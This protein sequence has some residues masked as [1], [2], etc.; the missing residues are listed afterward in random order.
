LY[1]IRD[2]IETETFVTFRITETDEKFLHEVFSDSN[3][4]PGSLTVSAEVFKLDGQVLM[5]VNIGGSSSVIW[6]LDGNDAV[7]DVTS[8]N[9]GNVFTALA[10]GSFSL[11]TSLSG[12]IQSEGKWSAAG[13]GVIN[14]ELILDGYEAL[15]FW[16][17]ISTV[18]TIAGSAHPDVA[19]SLEAQVTNMLTS[20]E[21]YFDFPSDAG[22]FAG[23]INGILAVG[24][25]YMVGPDEISYLYAT[26]ESTRY[27]QIWVGE[28]L[29]FDA[30][31]NS[32]GTNSELY[33]YSQPSGDS[34]NDHY[35][36]YRR[37]VTGDDIR[38]IISTPVQWGAPFVNYYA[39]LKFNSSDLT[40]SF[41]YR[42]SPSGQF[43]SGS[44]QWNNSH[45]MLT[46]W[47]S[48]ASSGDYWAKDVFN[49]GG[50]LWDGN[51]A[52]GYQFSGSW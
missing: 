12:V 7:F 5:D 46:F 37:N 18:N 43:E 29:Y 31:E 44:T 38:V 19:A 11:V 50:G 24:L 1:R 41:N 22:T 14:G 6:S 20:L 30:I 13:F 36:R 27:H 48:N 3:P 34:E 16:D 26:D 17:D 23:D 39:D 47:D 51:T 35:R 25:T 32:A 52:S 49:W 28:T 40:G 33:D 8:G 15:K 21:S 4:D 10:D 9:E 42:L 2:G 45:W